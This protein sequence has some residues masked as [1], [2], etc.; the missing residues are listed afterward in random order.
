MFKSTLGYSAKDWFPKTLRDSYISGL[1]VVNIFIPNSLSFY[2][3]KIRSL[4]LQ[5]LLANALSKYL[6]AS[7]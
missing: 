3:F 4:K 6:A 2:V 5:Y 1:L 7:V